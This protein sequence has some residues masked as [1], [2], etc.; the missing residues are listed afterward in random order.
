MH[1]MPSFGKCTL[2]KFPSLFPWVPPLFEAQYWRGESLGVLCISSD[3]GNMECHSSG[4]Y[5][6]PSHLRVCYC[7]SYNPMHLLGALQ[8]NFIVVLWQTVFVDSFL[9]GH[10][11]WSLVLQ[12][13]IYLPVSSKIDFQWKSLGR[14]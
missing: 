12:C 8:Y 4:S 3:N 6:I 5:C 1:S 13:Q 7:N 2:P 10:L 11:D 9:K 14:D